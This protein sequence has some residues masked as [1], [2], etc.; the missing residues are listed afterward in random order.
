MKRFVALLLTILLMVP[1][2]VAGAED[3]IAPEVTMA[4]ESQTTLMPWGTNIGT[5]CLWEVYEGL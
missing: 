4:I 3:Y 5:E 2:T 1:M